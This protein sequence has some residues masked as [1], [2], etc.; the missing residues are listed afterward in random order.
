MRISDWSSDVCSSD[1]PFGFFATVDGLGGDGLVPVSTLGSE[2]FFYDE[3]ARSL[4]SEHGRVSFTVGQRL[5]LRLMDANPISG[6][7]RFELPD[8][9]EGGFRGRPPRRDGMKGKDKAGKHIVGK[10]GRPAHMKH[11]GRKR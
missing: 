3:A 7:L 10:R 11:K 1:L 2:R 8:A 6:A 5:D 9:P 4:D